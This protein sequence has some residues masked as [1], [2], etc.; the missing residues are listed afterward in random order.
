MFPISG[1]GISGVR[2]SNGSI[3]IDKPTTTL[4]VVTNVTTYTPAYTGIITFTSN[5]TIP[6]GL[7]QLNFSSTGGYIVMFLHYNNYRDITLNTLSSS[8]SETQAVIG[9]F[10]T[11]LLGIV[12]LN[13]S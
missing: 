13:G 11:L 10:T 2:H 12:V 8:K 5:L 7:Y 9:L 6:Q 3:T 1:G 4:N